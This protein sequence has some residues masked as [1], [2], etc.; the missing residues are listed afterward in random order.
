MN[1]A[2][3]GGT[4]RKGYSHLHLDPQVLFGS[5]FLPP[6]LSC[7]YGTS[8]SVSSGVSH[9]TDEDGEAQREY[10]THPGT[11]TRGVNSIF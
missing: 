1:G 8:I 10:V 5:G 6:T 3:D 7:S 4:M 11:M 9:V 2:R